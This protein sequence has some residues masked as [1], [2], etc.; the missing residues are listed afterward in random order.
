MK[1][2]LIIISALVVFLVSCTDKF[3]EFNTDRKNP[4]NVTGET[5]FSNAE[6]ALTD[7]VSST[8]VNLNVFKLFSQYWTETTYTDEANYDIINRGI[9]DLTFREYYRG[10]L[11]DFQ[12]ARN[13]IIAAPL[14][15]GDNPALKVN[16]LAVI[17]LLQ[18]YA[19][20]NLVD[21]F[22]NVPYSEALDINNIAPKYDDAFTIYKDLINRIDTSLASIDLTAGSFGSA[23][24]IYGG[25]MAKWHK[26]GNSLKFRLGITLADVDQGL[27]RATVESA[28][29]GGIFE[30]NDDNALL[31]YLSAIHVNPLYED[32]IQSGRDDFVPANTIVDI[33]N[34]K[35][36]PR[37][38]LYFTM[39]GGQYRGGIYG[40]SSPFSQYSHIAGQITQPDFPGILLT[41]DEMLFYRAEAAARGFNVGGAPEQFYNAAITA[42]IEFWG[43]TPA[44]AA[45]YILTPG[46]AYNNPQSGATWQQKIGT[47][48]Y[49]AFY[50]RGL[51]AFNQ[52]R[53][54]DYP[55]LN[56]PPVLE[57]DYSGIPK[58]LTYP[59][60]EQT[61]NATNYQAAVAAIG[62]DKLTTKVFWDVNDPAPVK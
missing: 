58:R 29:A 52:W 15:A 23:D 53:R 39:S 31:Y 44:Q 28:V 7:Q 8:N 36:D 24:L 51:E 56:T 25:D 10:F 17:D 35:Q 20:Q 46:V 60:N 45:A 48:S 40:E 21:I 11:R 59:V 34:L 57:G 2:N 61:L 30:S 32:V 41:Y 54:L 4:A 5:V 22:G 38:Q 43:G 13:L 50:T 9:P 19:F 16:K 55:V 14:Q 62:G 6:L 26:F 3:E 47:Q 49:I 18:V 42:S 37:R 27:S 1:T 12:E 33:M